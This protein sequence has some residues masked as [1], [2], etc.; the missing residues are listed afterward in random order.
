[1][2][3]KTALYQT[4][5]N[6]GAKTGA[7]AGYDMPLYYDEGVMKEHLWTRSQAGLFD[8]S[9]MG[10]IMIEG[11]NAAQFWERLTPSGFA[12][13]K[14]GRAQYTALLNEEGGIIDDLI[15][16][17]LEQDRFFAVINAGCKDKDIEWIKSQLPPELTLT[18]LEDRALIALQGPK[19]EEVIRE[20]LGLDL[21]SM[22]YMWMQENVAGDLHVSRLGYTGEDGF[23]ISLSNDAAVDLAE[24]LLAH[25]AVK[26]VG[27][28]ARDS[29]RLEM[30]YALYGHDIDDKTSPVEAGMGWVISKK[31]SGYLGYER[32][33][34]ELENGPAKKLVGI[35][36]LDKGVA[37][38]GA[39][40]KN[41]EDEIIGHLTSG[42]HSPSLG[43]SIGQGYVQSDFAAEGQSIFVDV[44]GRKLAAEITA[45]PFMKGQTKAM[46]KKVA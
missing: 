15:V 34:N 11:A 24:R 30:G 43:L 28:A 27:L 31:T 14:I 9:H 3:K 29:L 6:L 42:G 12:E 17:R 23:E 10:Q 45:R 7:F 38:E 20:V 35:K 2:L 44:R 39:E 1:M 37:R 18:Y 22:P 40:L 19:S 32:I 5:I 25:D 21:S 46:K 4:H 26:P 13:K 41:A 16:T 36:L 8:V 33:Q